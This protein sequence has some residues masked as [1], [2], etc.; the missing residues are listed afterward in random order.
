M[1]DP[2]D[3]LTDRAQ[4]VRDEYDAIY[5]EPDPR[6]YFR[7]LHGL[8]Y[9]IPELARPVFKNIINSVADVR[10]QPARVLDLGCGFGINAALLRTQLDMNRLAHRFRDLDA[11]DILPNRVMELDRHYFASW[12]RMINA[13]FVGLDVSPSPVPTPKTSVCS[14]SVS[15]RISRLRTCR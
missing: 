11:S 14:I 4:D 2:E 7:V 13:E 1:T 6:A 8:D 5:A 9:M 3:L 15:R 10:S 12:P